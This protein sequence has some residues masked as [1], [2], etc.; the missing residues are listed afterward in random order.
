M[1]FIAVADQIREQF[2]S[3]EVIK[4]FSED[5]SSQTIKKDNAF[6]GNRIIT[7]NCVDC[8]EIVSRGHCRN[9]IIKNPELID[10]EPKHKKKVR[11][12]L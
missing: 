7:E 8:T 9:I 4:Q 5:A 12:K 1:G 2:N 11:Q 10:I 3:P 6:S